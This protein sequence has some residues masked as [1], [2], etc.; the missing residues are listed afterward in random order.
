MHSID[1]RRLQRRVN[2]KRLRD[3]TTRHNTREINDHS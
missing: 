2:S 1:E 3:V